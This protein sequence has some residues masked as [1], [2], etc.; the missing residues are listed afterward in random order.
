MLGQANDRTPL[1][2]VVGG[3]VSHP[4]RP[5]GE[6][7]KPPVPSGRSITT[8]SFIRT[9]HLSQRAQSR[10]AIIGR[11]LFRSSRL[12]AMRVGMRGMMP[13]NTAAALHRF[14]YGSRHRWTN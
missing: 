11:K 1:R 8:A 7:F 13:K 2:P 6:R 12:G 3:N 4:P 5:G 9:E 10:A 14:K